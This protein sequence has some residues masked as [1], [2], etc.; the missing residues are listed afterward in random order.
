[1]PVFFMPRSTTNKGLEALLFIGFAF[2]VWLAMR[3]SNTEVTKQINVEL[4][5][6]GRAVNGQWLED[7]TQELNVIIEAKG[8]DALF[9][10]RFDE[11]L[12]NFNSDDFLRSSRKNAYLLNADIQTILKQEYGREYSFNW[13]GDSLLFPASL[14]ISKKLPVVLIAPENIS[15][16]ESHRWIQPPTLEPDSIVC[17]GPEALLMNYQPTISVPSFTWSGSDRKEVPLDKLPKYIHS[18][19]NWLTITA[20]ADAWTEVEYRTNLRYHNQDFPIDL[21]LSGPMS[22]LV[23]SLEASVN[24]EWR[25]EDRRIRVDV[26]PLTPGVEILDYEPKYIQ[27]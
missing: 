15:L 4:I 8:L 10:D 26:L 17:E 11:R 6:V 2:A 23:H 1:M 3:I 13:P 20:N 19:V 9:M 22:I 24:I 14:L 25:M 27:P 18:K 5:A 12:I 16:P 7:S 21:W